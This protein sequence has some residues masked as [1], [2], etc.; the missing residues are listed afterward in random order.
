MAERMIGRA[1]SRREDR[2]LLRGTGRFVDDFTPP[3]TAHMA[4]LRSPFAHARIRSVDLGSALAAPG[5][6]DAFRGADLDRPL[7]EIPFRLA[8][9]SGFDRFLQQP[10]ATDKARFAGEPVAVVVASGR[11]AAEDAL[12]AIEVDYEPLQPVAEPEAAAG[13]DTLVHEGAGDNV[14][15]R[16]TVGR[17]DADAAFAAA[18]YRRSE[19]F[20]T[21]RQTALPLE[22]RGLVADFGDGEN[23]EALGCGQGHAF[24]Q[25]GARPGLRPARGGGRADPAS[26]LA[27]ASGCA[28]SSTPRT[29]WS[30]SPAA[31]R[32]AP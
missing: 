25:A 14:A 16:Y 2:P 28:A 12:A 8:G 21:H 27:A 10:I 20:R 4:I 6:I 22:T 9:L 23:P 30:L 15:I 3:G 13:C 7:P 19:R 17:G 32:G 26:M 1:L 29:T 24:Q 5:V 31:A 11:Y 18:P